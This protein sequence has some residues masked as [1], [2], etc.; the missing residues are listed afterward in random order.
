MGVSV[1][2]CWEYCYDLLNKLIACSVVGFHH[3]AVFFP[4]FLD[5]LYMNLMAVSAEHLTKVK[6][7]GYSS[8]AVSL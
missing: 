1:S 7:P 8:S 5:R 3:V 6:Q 4:C 2:V